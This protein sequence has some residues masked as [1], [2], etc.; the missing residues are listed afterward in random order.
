MYDE[1]LL[2]VTLVGRPILHGRSRAPRR[3]RRAYLVEH[4]PAADESEPTAR[5][6]APLEPPD[7]DASGPGLRPL[8][9]RS[10]GY[11]VVIPPEY[12]GIRTCRRLYVEYVTGERELYDLPR[13]RADLHNLAATAR[14]QLLRR[15]AA[16]LARLK[17]CQGT[18]C[19]AAEEARRVLP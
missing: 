11:K 10:R 14:P 6:G 2:R 5:G 17:T 4:W 9:R 18:E 16:R 8:A 7:P 1:L 3:W 13:D 15:L 19:R 12:H